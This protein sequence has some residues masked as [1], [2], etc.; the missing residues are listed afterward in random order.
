MNRIEILEAAWK[1]LIDDYTPTTKVILEKLETLDSAEDKIHYLRSEEIEYLINVT[2]NPNLCAA[3]GVVTTNNPQKA[4]LDRWIELKIREIEL[5]KKQ[6]KK[7]GK[8]TSYIWQGNN[9]DKELSELYNLM[10]NKY[11]LIA[12]ETT[13]EQFKAIFTGQPI[14]EN[15]ESIRWHQ[16]NASEV[17]YFLLRLIETNNI[18]ASRNKFIILNH[19]FIKNSG[20]KFD[21]NWKQIN[22]SLSINLSKE[23][24]KRIDDLIADF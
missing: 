20:S 17:C 4:G 5:F 13:F 7:N 9:P 19:C 18:T 16:D 3:S 14:D 22:H 2:L 12:P 15:F 8:M 21:V 23:K 1:K 6:S 10:I 11:N 24:Q